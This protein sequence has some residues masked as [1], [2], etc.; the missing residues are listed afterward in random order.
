MKE[1][2]QLTPCAAYPY[3]DKIQVWLP[4]PLD[5][6]TLDELEAQCGLGGLYQQT[7]PARFDPAFRQRLELRQPSVDAL[8][9]AAG[10]NDI[11]LNRAEIAVDYIFSKEAQQKA[12][13]RFFDEHLVRR[14]H[15]KHQK[16]KR[17]CRSSR[18]GK[19]IPQVVDHIELAETRYDAGRSCNK[20][21]CYL[22]PVSRVTGE[23]DCLHLEWHCNGVRACR[24]AGIG[25]T[26]E[27]LK[28]D[29]RQFWKDR[30]LLYEVDAE[31]LG[32][33]VRNKRDGT[34]SRNANIE[35]D[36]RM[37]REVNLDLKAGNHFLRSTSCAQELIDKMGPCTAWG[38]RV[39]RALLPIPNDVWLPQAI[40]NG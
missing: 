16:I 4:V 39:H 19:R 34:R 40:G 5:Q 33:L 7:G 8:T 24:A 18:D 17:V 30:L 2:A 27:L 25:S 11:L 1:P 32:R 37:R 6:R 3:F 10:R 13:F 9:W 22:D 38:I 28:F 31:K 20:I 23:L 12:A 21:A 29:H 14:W 15:G 26:S 35:Y 36:K